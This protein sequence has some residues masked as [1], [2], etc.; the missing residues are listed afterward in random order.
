MVMGNKI[1]GG[2]AGVMEHQFD[3]SSELYR[4]A[5]RNLSQKVLRHERSHYWILIKYI[6]WKLKV[7]DRAWN[8]RL[9]GS[10]RSSPQPESFVEGLQCWNK[11]ECPLPVSKSFFSADYMCFMIKHWTFQET[12]SKKKLS[13]LMQKTTKK[14]NTLFWWYHQLV[15]NLGCSFF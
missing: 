13:K 7:T 6:L 10:H 9:K 12:E 4:F 2:I 15:W 1:I 8:V 14:I 11:K 3:K 5:E